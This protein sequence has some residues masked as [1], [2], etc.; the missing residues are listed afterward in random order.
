M[1][2]PIVLFAVLYTLSPIFIEVSKEMH[3]VGAI[4]L[5][6][7]KW[8]DWLILAISCAALAT[9]NLMSFFSTKWADYKK[10]KEGTAPPFK[11]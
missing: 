2:L 8:G 10:E 7:Y 9:T 4:K 6:E 3:D 1:K 11:V 5:M